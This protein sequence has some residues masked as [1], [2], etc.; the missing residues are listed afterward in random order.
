MS[1]IGYLG[2]LRFVI[3]KRL[4]ESG[5]A[6]ASDDLEVFLNAASELVPSEAELALAAKL[7]EVSLPK[8]LTLDEG[9]SILFSAAVLR[10]IN[11]VLTGDKRAIC[12]CAHVTTSVDEIGVLK[13]RMISLE[14]L[15]GT[16]IEILGQDEVR[17]RVCS[18]KTADK[19]AAI[20][21]SCGAERLVEG[22]AM[23]ALKSYQSDLTS[24]SDGFS[25]DTLS[26]CP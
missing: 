3:G 21:F 4:A 8:G 9:E 19:T 13:G 6:E 5:N 14:Q 18:D 25:S 7:Q 15:L 24:K 2:S 1:K 16:L 10:A 26:C 11:S 17:K 20:C 22:S 12:C 23:Q